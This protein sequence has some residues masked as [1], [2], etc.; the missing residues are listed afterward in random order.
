M[1]SLSSASADEMSFRV[2]DR[3]SFRHSSRIWDQ[4]KQTTLPNETVCKPVNFLMILCKFMFSRA[5]G[6]LTTPETLRVVRCH[7]AYSGIF[8]VRPSEK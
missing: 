7:W 6:L 5:C 3:R 4:K 2:Y 8:P 1:F